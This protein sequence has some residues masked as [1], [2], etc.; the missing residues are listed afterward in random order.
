MAG[1]YRVELVVGDTKDSEAQTVQEYQRIKDDVVMFSEVL[2]TPPTQALLEF[3]NEDGVVAVPGSLAGAWAREP[4]LLPNGAAYEFEA[5]NL[6]D[7]YVN[8]SGHGERK[9]TCTA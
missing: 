6:A 9:P 3:L 4:L 2:S 7:W 5:I 1:K 8:H